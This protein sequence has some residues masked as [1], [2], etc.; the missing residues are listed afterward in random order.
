M[1]LD[2]ASITYANIKKD[3]GIFINI[4][5][6]KDYSTIISS[7]DDIYIDLYGGI[8]NAMPTGMGSVA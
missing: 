5:A 4:D 1:K 7:S 8:F 2:S 3:H 6:R